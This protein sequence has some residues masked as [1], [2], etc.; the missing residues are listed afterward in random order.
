MGIEP[1]IVVPYPHRMAAEWDPGLARW[2]FDDA[3]L[4]AG[5]REAG[6]EPSKW[7]VRP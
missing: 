3:I 7:I 2:A 5:L 4:T 6:L 1:D